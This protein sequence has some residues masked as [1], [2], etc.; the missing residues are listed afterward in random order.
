MAGGEAG[1]CPGCEG[2]GPRGALVHGVKDTSGG[3][4]GRGFS[5]RLQGPDPIGSCRSL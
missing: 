1:V 4:K 2:R 5:E 3:T